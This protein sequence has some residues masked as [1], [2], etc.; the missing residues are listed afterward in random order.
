L[1][2]LGPIVRIV[3]GSRRGWLLVLEALLVALGAVYVVLDL[4]RLVAPKQNES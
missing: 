2:A 1:I 4:R 3:S